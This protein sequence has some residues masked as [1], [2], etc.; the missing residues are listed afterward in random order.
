VN[1]TYQ[2]SKMENKKNRNFLWNAKTRKI[3][4]GFEGIASIKNTT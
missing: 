4:R 1:Q 2:I 3:M